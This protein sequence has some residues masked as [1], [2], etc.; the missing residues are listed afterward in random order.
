VGCT[1]GLCCVAL[2]DD[3]TDQPCCP[4]SDYGAHVVCGDSG[5]CVQDE[6]GS[7]CRNPFITEC[8]W[9]CEDEMCCTSLEEVCDPDVDT[10]CRGGEC[11]PWG[12][13]Y[14]CQP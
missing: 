10:C 4:T 8:L 14:R 2:G 3:C 12:N 5:R 11:A 7:P 13:E 6:D 1:H 9:E